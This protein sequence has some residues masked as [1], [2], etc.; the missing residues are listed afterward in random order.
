MTR[1][2]CSRVCKGLE[3][4]ICVDGRALRRSYNSD[5]EIVSRL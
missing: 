1:S 4:M 5:S 3:G 2:R